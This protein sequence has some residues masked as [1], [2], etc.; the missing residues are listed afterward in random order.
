[1]SM[2]PVNKVATS[3]QMAYQCMVFWNT[4]TTFFFPDSPFQPYNKA[5][6]QAFPECLLFMNSNTTCQINS[7][8]FD[9]WSSSASKLLTM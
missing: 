9:H 1:M 7:G 2:S 5:N 3:S 8:G 6:T 4:A